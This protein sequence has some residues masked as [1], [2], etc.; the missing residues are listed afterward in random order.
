MSDEGIIDP[1]T[2]AEIPRPEKVEPP[3]PEPKEEPT[4]E[5]AKREGRG[6]K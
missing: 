2:G 4:H 3:T 5:P 1:V 6:A